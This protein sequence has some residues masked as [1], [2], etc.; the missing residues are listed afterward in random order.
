MSFVT[1]YVVSNKNGLVNG[2][3]AGTSQA[4]AMY[5]LGGPM[6]GQ[7]GLNGDLLAIRVSQ[8]MA[9]EIYGEIAARHPTKAAQLMRNYAHSIQKVGD[10]T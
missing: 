1:M 6:A 7:Y 2:S 10:I 9:D 8:S 3:V 4:D 5:H